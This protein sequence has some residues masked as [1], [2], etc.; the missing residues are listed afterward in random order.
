MLYTSLAIPDSR[1]GVLGTTEMAGIGTI[2]LAKIARHP[3]AGCNI[4]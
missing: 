4:C 1:A 2:T 3:A